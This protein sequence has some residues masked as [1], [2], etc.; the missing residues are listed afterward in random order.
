MSQSSTKLSA[1]RLCSKN[2]HSKVLELWDSYQLLLEDIFIWIPHYSL[3]S[4]SRYFF[5]AK[6]W[7]RIGIFQMETFYQHGQFLW[8]AANATWWLSGLQREGSRSKF[9]SSA[10]FCWDQYI[11][12]EYVDSNEQELES[13]SVSQ[14]P[15]FILPQRLGLIHVLDQYELFNSFHLSWT[16]FQH[17]FY[18]FIILPIQMLA[19]HP[20]QLIQTKIILHLFCRY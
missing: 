8:R 19:F 15:F 11:S 7:Q 1:F 12:P 3:P 16:T 14:L 2:N 9:L 6:T 5:L 17:I 13:T 10:E 4:F 20:F 18:T